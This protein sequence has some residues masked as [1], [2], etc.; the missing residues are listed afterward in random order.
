[1]GEEVILID[2]Q[3]HTSQSVES[4]AAQQQT[5]NYEVLCNIGR[6]VPRVYFVQEMVEISNELLK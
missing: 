6:R 4:L 3:A 1:M 5:I 2:D